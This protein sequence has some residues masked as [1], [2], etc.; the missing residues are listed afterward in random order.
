MPV[1]PV[2][3]IKCVDNRKSWHSVKMSNS[4]YHD[5]EDSAKKGEFEHEESLSAAPYHGWVDKELSQFVTD[6][7]VEISS[8]RN[9]ELVRKLDKRVLPVLVVAC[10]LQALTQSTLP[11]ASIMGLIEDTGMR[12]PDGRTSQQ[13]RNQAMDLDF[14]P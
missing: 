8:E 10:L 11:F 6:V 13:V 12:R 1:R 3:G 5:A 2:N 7:A 14:V 4:T 9:K